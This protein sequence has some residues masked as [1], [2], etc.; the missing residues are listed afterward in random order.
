MNDWSTMMDI[1]NLPDVFGMR[2]YI[3]WFDHKT[4]EDQFLVG[5][6]TIGQKAMCGK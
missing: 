4:H 2:G 1:K 5:E 3:F 6:K